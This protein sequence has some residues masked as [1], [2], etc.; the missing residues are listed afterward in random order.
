MDFLPFQHLGSRG[1][2][3]IFQYLAAVG[4]SLLESFWGEGVVEMKDRKL[5]L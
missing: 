4:L 1:K 3:W 2:P 5:G